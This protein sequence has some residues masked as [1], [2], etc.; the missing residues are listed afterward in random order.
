M[1]AYVGKRLR[2]F[3]EALFPKLFHQMTKERRIIRCVCVFYLRERHQP[4]DVSRSFSN[5]SRSS[6]EISVN[7]L[8][9][10]PLKLQIFR[11]IGSLYNFIT[12]YRKRTS[13]TA[14]RASSFDNDVINGENTFVY[15]SR[16]VRAL[17]ITSNY[18]L[19]LCEFA[20]EL[21][22]IDI[23]IGY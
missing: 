3:F 14:V 9:D 17:V 20:M 18:D 21:V 23:G 7:R 15:L 5:V 8:V 16:S 19:S 13:E 2:D 22:G 4:E 6:V 1:Y 10:Y 11:I 12:K